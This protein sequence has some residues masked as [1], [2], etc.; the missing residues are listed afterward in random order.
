M[1]EV[2]I[3]GI[4]IVPKPKPNAGG[5]IIIAWFSC[6]ANGFGLEDCA[7]VRT[8]KHGLTVWPPKLNGPDSHRRGVTIMDDSLRSAMMLKAREAYRVLGGSEAEWISRWSADNAAN[9]APAAAKAP[10]RG[11]VSVRRIVSEDTAGLSRFL[12]PG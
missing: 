11:I 8:N 3:T 10:V 2:E 7:L 9:A 4:N 5:S 12:S 1:N 6:L